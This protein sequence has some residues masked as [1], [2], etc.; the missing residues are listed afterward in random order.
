MWSEIGI[1]QEST[2]ISREQMENY[3][4]DIA[5]RLHLG[6]KGLEIQEQKKHR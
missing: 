4:K 1:K 3:A 5:N 2:D 6:E